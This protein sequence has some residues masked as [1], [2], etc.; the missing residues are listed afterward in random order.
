M[1]GMLFGK[2]MPLHKGHIE[3]IEFALQRCEYLYVVLCYT[4]KEPIAG[5]LRAKWLNK[6]LEQKSNVSL[7]IYQYDET[8]LPNTSVSS[9]DAS[10]RWAN[11]F[12]TILP[13]IDVLFTSEIY[14]NYLSEFMQIHHVPFDYDR[15]RVPVS[16]T[17]IR[18][19]PFRYWDYIAD[20]AKPWFVKK[21]SV[22]GTESTGKSILAKSLAETFSTV[23]VPE[24]ARSIVEKT[25][26]CTISDLYKIAESQAKA[27][28]TALLSA[29]KLLFVDTDLATTRSYARFLF[30]E[31]LTVKK[32]ITEVNKFDLHLFLE[33]DCE[34][35][36]DGTRLS[37]EQRNA[38]SEHHKAHFK[39]EGI[40]LAP[41]N[42]NWQDRFNQAQGLIR[43]HFFT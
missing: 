13:A 31:E 28:E 18:E 11:A 33:P 16:A 23:F 26:E 37:L 39:Q 22:V 27:I 29:N 20:T 10:E 21:V 43:R 17:M 35:V 3:L 14:G 9:R 24:M 38:L 15:V 32:W 19:N 4:S 6:L 34:Y 30:G 7:I 25:S 36:Q 40:Q 42:G 2:F 8:N 12:K 41:I 1:T 5:P